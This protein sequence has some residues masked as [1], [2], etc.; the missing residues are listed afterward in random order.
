M[1]LKLKEGERYGM[2]TVVGL[3]GKHPTNGGYMWRVTC[4][5]G[6]MADIRASV[7]TKGRTRS[8]G[9]LRR[10]GH[11]RHGMSGSKVHMA[12]KAMRQRCENENRPQ[13][14]DW[15]GRGITFAPE[16]DSFEQ[17]HSDMG[18][19]PPGSSLERRDNA[20]GYSKDNCYWATPKQQNRNRR[21]TRLLEYGGQQRTLQEWAEACGIPYMTLFYRIKRGWSL[22]RAISAGRFH[23]SGKF[24]P[25][26]DR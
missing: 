3:A 10:Q 15:G 23:R 11:P 21:I 4:D 17:F 1:T 7:L 22:D 20:K 8:C 24:T 6:G 13:W 18:D 9:C 26:K 5:C 16:W 12:W 14:E 25:S 2:L 19:P